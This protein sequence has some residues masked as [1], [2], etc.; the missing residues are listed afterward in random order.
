MVTSAFAYL[1]LRAPP[2]RIPHG[3]PVRDPWDRCARP[4]EMSSRNLATDHNCR[5]PPTFT[6]IRHLRQQNVSPG[7]DPMLEDDGGWSYREDAPRIAGQALRKNFDRIKCH[8]NKT[9]FTATTRRSRRTMRV[10]FIVA[11]RRGDFAIMP[12]TKM[13]RASI[14]FYGLKKDQQYQINRQR[15]LSVTIK[16]GQVRTVRF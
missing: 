5:A 15:Q 16:R 3:A 1:P 12:R 2:F 11:C 13:S 10:N 7:R 8:V 9:L 14:V 4:L 6:S